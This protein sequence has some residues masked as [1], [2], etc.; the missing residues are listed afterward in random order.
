MTAD[1]SNTFEPK[2]NILTWF[3]A[4]HED[5]MHEFSESIQGDEFRCDVYQATEL[6]QMWERDMDREAFR[7]VM[8]QLVENLIRWTHRYHPRRRNYLVHMMDHDTYEMIDEKMQDGELFEF[9]RSHF[10]NLYY[11]SLIT[12][13]VDC[14]DCRA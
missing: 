3:L 7:H 13:D 1:E 2:R 12:K 4:N 9:V 14:E 8:G 11:V 6:V 5:I 10:W